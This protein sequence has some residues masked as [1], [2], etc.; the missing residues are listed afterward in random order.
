[1]SISTIRFGDVAGTLEADTN[2]L[3]WLIQRLAEGRD[4]QFLAL[5]AQDLYANADFLLS[6][7]TVD[8]QRN[9]FYYGVNPVKHEIYS[10]SK[11]RRQ[12]GLGDIKGF[13]ADLD[14]KPGAFESKEAILNFLKLVPIRP[15]TITESGS[16]GI[17]ATWKASGQIQPE[18][19]KAW[20][21]YLQSL[22]PEGVNID[23]LVNVDRILRL[24]GSVRWSKTGA[25]TS[26]VK[27]IDGCRE[28]HDVAEFKNLSKEAYA[29]YR[30]SQKIVRAQKTVMLDRK[31][32]SISQARP[33][34]VKAICES[35]SDELDW[36]EI[37]EPAG[38]TFQR[39][40]SDGSRHWIRPGSSQK[41]AVTD[42]THS[43]GTVSGVM[44]LLSSSPDSG[45]L[46]LKEAGIPLTKFHV[47]LRLQFEDDLD[48]LIKHFY[49]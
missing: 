12:A 41:S 29:G 16:G 11:T 40:N 27:L 30:T 45:L 39:E 7:H 36:A 21:A 3:R 38:W 44:S 48:A 49:N 10:W 14:V 43:D 28:V 25:F 2:S 46:D 22:A 37:L 1:M 32:N 6:Q 23:R 4:R 33:G 5:P 31:F 17:H 9:D 20:W 42:Y 24:P 15:T 34:Y 18:D 35:K 19:L 47:L 26:T 8:G 13:F